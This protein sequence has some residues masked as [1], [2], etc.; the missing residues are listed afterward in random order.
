M[1]QGS[2]KTLTTYGD[3]VDGVIAGLEDTSAQ[4]DQAS[5]FKH[6]T[7]HVINAFIQRHGARTALIATKGFRD[8]LEIGRGNR[9][10]T[11]DLRYRRSEPLIP[12]SL[13]FEIAERMDG[14]GTWCF[15]LMSRA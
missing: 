5:L 2:G 9:P 12:R 8:I 3:L 15:R 11:F 6:G 10:E 13:R 4:L 1:R 7:T 14:R